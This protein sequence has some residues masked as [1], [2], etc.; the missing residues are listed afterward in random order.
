[1]GQIQLTVALIMIGLFTVAII[2]F[3]VNF[4]VDNEAA[5]KIT[6]DAEMSTLY[7]SASGNVKDFGTDSESQYQSI[8]ETTLEAGA[9]SPQSVAPFAITFAI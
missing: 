7:S 4:A 5:V 6:D 8:I 1:M 3:A 2:A 9:D